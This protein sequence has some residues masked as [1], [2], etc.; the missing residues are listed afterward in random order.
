MS[1]SYWAGYVA[2]GETPEM[3]EKKFE[4]LEEYIKQEKTVESQAIQ[5]PSENKVPPSLTE[6]DLEK[7]FKMTSHFVPPTSDTEPLSEV[8][9]GLDDFYDETDYLSDDED[10]YIDNEEDDFW[11]DHLSSKKRKKGSQ[12][13]SREKPQ[14]TKLISMEVV[15]VDGFTYT[16]KKK[17]KDRGSLPT[18]VR[19]DSPSSHKEI[20]GTSHYTIYNTR[21]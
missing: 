4:R 7:V 2:D 19:Q 21:S 13:K 15:G 14:K 3:I 9:M 6:E 12:D 16:V 10:Q 11:A 1:V 5:T 17:S 8:Y 18:N 20:L